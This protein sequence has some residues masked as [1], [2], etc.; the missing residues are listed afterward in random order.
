MN[1][2]HHNPMLH[3]DLGHA[4]AFQEALQNEH[5]NLRQ[6]A[7]IS[8]FMKGI[9]IL[10]SWERALAIL[11]EAREGDFDFLSNWLKERLSNRFLVKGSAFMDHFLSILGERDSKVS[12]LIHGDLF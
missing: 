12:M 9:R 6:R 10:G 2:V 4:F 8:G 3:D 7:I 5:Q 11:E 1:N